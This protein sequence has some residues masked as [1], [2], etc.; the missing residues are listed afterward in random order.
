MWHWFF[1][2]YF[3]GYDQ[4]HTGGGHAAASA[5]PE[6]DASSGILAV[7]VVLAALALAWEIKRRRRVEG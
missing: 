6:M 3:G 7:A 5:V 4:D 2:R 1:S